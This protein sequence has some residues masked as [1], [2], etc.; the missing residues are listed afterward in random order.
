MIKH[1]KAIGYKMKTI[2]KLISMIFL[3]IITLIAVMEIINRPLMIISVFIMY[4]WLL[5][6]I[7]N[8]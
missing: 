7:S 1:D 2:M 3:L 4:I 8:A 6:T 5:H